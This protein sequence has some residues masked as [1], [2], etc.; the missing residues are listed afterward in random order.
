MGGDDCSIYLWDGE[1]GTPPP[2]RDFKE[3]SVVLAVAHPN[4][5][6]SASPRTWSTWSAVGS[7]HPGHADFLS[8]PARYVD[9]G[10]GLCS[11]VLV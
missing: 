2:H 3:R 8:G 6:A 10:G 1:D 4:P 11:G 9:Q 7:S 5:W